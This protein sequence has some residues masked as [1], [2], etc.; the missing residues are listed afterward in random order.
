[1]GAGTLQAGG[2][3]SSLLEESIPLDVV[4]QHRSYAFQSSVMF[5]HQFAA[6]VL[7][8]LGYPDQAAVRIHAALTLAQKLA[9]PF[10]LAFTTASAAQFYQHHRDGA[11]AYRQDVVAMTVAAEQEFALPL[12]IGKMIRGWALSVQGCEERGIAQLREGLAAW[13]TTGAKNLMSYFLALLAEAHGQAGQ[14]EE[15]LSAVAEAL[16]V[17]DTTLG[18]ASGRRSCIG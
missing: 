4:E 18:S 7:W 3:G 6:F 9:S 8:Q 17:V 14:T 5:C 1:V 12:V 13:Q 15:G 2:R 11:A 10:G 16:T